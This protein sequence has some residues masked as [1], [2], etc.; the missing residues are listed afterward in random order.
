MPA[1]GPYLIALTLGSIGL[2]LALIFAVS[3]HDF[4]ALS[5]R[6]SA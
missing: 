6:W 2:L 4:L 5:A 3:L 1:N